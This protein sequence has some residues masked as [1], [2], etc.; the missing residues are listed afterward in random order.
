VGSCA[1][2][3]PSQVFSVA[4]SG[5]D[6]C[7]RTARRSSAS[8]PRSRLRSGRVRRSVAGFR[9]RSAPTGIWRCRSTAAASAP[10]KTRPSPVRRPAWDRRVCRRQPPVRAVR[11]PRTGS[12]VGVQHAGAALEQLDACLPPRPGAQLWTT[13]G[14]VL[15]RPG[16]PAVPSRT[17]GAVDPS[18]RDPRPDGAPTQ[19]LSALREIVAL[20]GMEP[21]RSSLRLADA[22]VYRRHGIDPPSRRWLSWRLAGLSRTASGMPLRSTITW[23]FC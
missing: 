8:L 10:D 22:A 1:S 9:R 14:G 4:T 2:L 23:C 12:G 21:G 13:A 19:R 17:L 7:C 16:R 3:F 6:F 18:S 11:G 20:V 15:P 5:S